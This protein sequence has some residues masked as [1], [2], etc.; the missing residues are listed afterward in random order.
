MQSLQDR[1]DRSPDF[2]EELRN[3]SA[4][5]YSFP[6]VASE[7]SNWRDEQLAWLNSAVLL[8][9][10]HH[11]TYQYMRGP[12]VLRLVSD[13][14]ANSFANFAVDRAKQIICCAPDGKF[15][16]DGIL[17]YLAENELLVVGRPIVPNWL[18]YHAETGGYDVEIVREE[19]S[20]SNPDGAPVNRSLYRYQVQ[21]P[22]AMDILTRL[23]DGIRPDIGFFRMGRIRIRGREVRCLRHGMAGT[24]GLEIWG[25]YEERAEIR[26]A[27][28][29]AGAEFGI[30]AVGSR[31]YASTVLSSGWIPSALPAIYTNEELRGYREWLPAGGY[32]ANAAIGGSFVPGRIEDYYL[33]PFEMGYGHAIRFDHDFIGREA[34]AAMDPS[35]HRRKVTY[36]WNRE[37]V[38]RVMASMFDPDDLPCKYIELPLS[39]YSSHDYD[40]VRA[41]DREVG[42]SMYPGCDWN[43]RSMMSLGIA[44]PDIGIG[45]EVE[46][47]WGEPDGGT[48]KKNVERHR[49]TVIR[50]RVEA[51]PYSDIARTS[52]ARGTWRELEA[53]T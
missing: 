15:I 32:E 49:Q 51:V 30:R 19:R 42:L 20:P 50:A 41:G 13:V 17:F 21:G 44:A 23:N 27:I 11:M 46:I 33:T 3:I 4:A 37:D 26:A 40:V 45:S 28:L 43:Y 9:Q 16:G 10:S 5:A 1:I 53:A 7:F 29:E 36:V 34:L 8:D 38:A 6:V 47:T 14:G 52:Y 35:T 31:A 18:K 48:S 2:L 25:P 12:D 24:P 39:I 22:R